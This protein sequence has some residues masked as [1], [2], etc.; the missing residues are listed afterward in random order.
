MCPDPIDIIN[1][2][3]TFTGNSVGDTATYTCNLGFELIG[4]ATRTCT[5]VN[6]NSTTFQ[7]AVPS[8]RREY[9]VNHSACAYSE[10]LPVHLC[11]TCVVMGVFTWSIK[12]AI[13]HLTV[14]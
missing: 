14:H 6:V 4:G 9:I 11:A 10:E 1:G 8:C 5:Q 2:I 3:V 13:T 12:S 7:P